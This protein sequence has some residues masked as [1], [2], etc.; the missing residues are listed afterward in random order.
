[1]ADA[2]ITSVDLQ[3]RQLCTLLTRYAF[4]YGSEIQLHEGIESVLLD[5]GVQ[6]EREVI[7]GGDRYD[8]LVSSGVVIEVKTKG[9]LPEA[10]TQCKRYLESERV[11]AV[12]LAG[13]RGWAN[14]VRPDLTF[15]SKPLRIVNLKPSAF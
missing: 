4:R 14:Q 13:T 10:L 9:S 1:M 6:F 2:V 5:A 15:N 11:R 12:I 3:L 8:F 7:D